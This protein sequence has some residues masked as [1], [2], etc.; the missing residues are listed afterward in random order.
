[1][2]QIGALMEHRAIA[3]WTTDMMVEQDL[4]ICRAIVEIYRD[5]FLAKRLVFRGGTA[6][7][8]LFFSPQPRYS[9]DLDFVQMEPEP[10]KETFDH[11][12][13]ALSFLGKG[14]VKQKRNNNDIIFR[15]ASEND[16]ELTLR[17]KVEINCME[18]FHILP[19]QIVPFKINNQW[20]SGSCSILTYQLEELVGTKF[21]ALYQRRK[22]R[23]LFDLYTALTRAELN[24]DSVLQCYERYMTFTTDHLPTYKEYVANMEE[25]MLDDEFLGDTTGLLQPSLKFSPKEGY[26]LIKRM[27]ID[28]LP[29]DRD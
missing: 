9:E 29:G 11:L 24:M 15:V 2:I 21:R 10:I 26:K 27:M 22:G 6:L 23:D 12:W 16:T 1:M 18:H 25:K 4:L 19:L 14:K 13:D 7:H 8:K 17:I 3:P 5:E 28:R 20:F